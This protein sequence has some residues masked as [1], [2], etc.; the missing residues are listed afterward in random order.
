MPRIKRKDESIFVNTPKSLLRDTRLSSEA[1]VLWL[2][3]A[4]MD[5]AK[6]KTPDP[7]K[8]H[9]AEDIVVCSVRHID[10]LLVELE[11]HHCLSRKTPLGKRS[12]YDVELP[13]AFYLP[14]QE[15]R[16]TPAPHA[17]V[18]RHTVPTKD[19]KEKDY[20]EKKEDVNVRGLEKIREMKKKHLPSME[21]NQ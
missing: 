18:P 15:V 8:K 9:L 13:E 7:S 6:K 5:F 2:Y 3:L 12:Y 17:S 4:S 20:K 21:L 14:R 11:K 19:Y 10:K 16:G 1:K